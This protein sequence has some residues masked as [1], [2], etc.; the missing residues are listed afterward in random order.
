MLLKYLKAQR[1]VQFESVSLIW[2][3]HFSIECLSENGLAKNVSGLEHKLGC[4][5]NTYSRAN[6]NHVLD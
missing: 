5:C 1:T 6:T 3:S 2:L 4:D